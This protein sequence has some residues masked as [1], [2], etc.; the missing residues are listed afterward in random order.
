MRNVCEADLLHRLICRIEEFDSFV[1]KEGFFKLNYVCMTQYDENLKNVHVAF[2]PE[3]LNNKLTSL[4]V[5]EL[6]LLEVLRVNHNQLT[7]LDI[8]ANI[9][10]IRLD[11]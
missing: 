7:T 2:K 8:S 4:D 10:L 6:T 1:R 5:S 3:V 9:K 11:I